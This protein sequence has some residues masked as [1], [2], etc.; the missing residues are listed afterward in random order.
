MN[1]GRA[2]SAGETEQRVR[3]ADVIYRRTG[4][5]AAQKEDGC[6]CLFRYDP[7]PVIS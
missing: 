5:V 6:Q 7:K 2:L 1:E 3:K 4:R